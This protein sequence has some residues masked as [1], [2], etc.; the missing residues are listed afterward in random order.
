VAVSFIGRGNRRK[1]WLKV[2]SLLI[3]KNRLFITRQMELKYDQ[4]HE[5]NK[6]NI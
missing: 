2:V 5:I 4:V 1:P 3:A 6:N